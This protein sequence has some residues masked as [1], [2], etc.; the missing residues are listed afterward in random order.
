MPTPPVS[1][2]DPSLVAEPP[3]IQSQPISPLY[4][5][6]FRGFPRAVVVMHLLGRHATAHVSGARPP[7]IPQNNAVK[8]PD[9][10]RDHP[11]A[12]L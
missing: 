3:P 10:G 9:L 8:F 7:E 6:A 1:I 11:N 5:A 4:L 12:A 2:L